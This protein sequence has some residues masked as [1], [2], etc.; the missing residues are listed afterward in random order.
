MPHIF[1]PPERLAEFCRKHHIVKL[2]FFGSVL[3]DDFGP[4]SDV[5]VLVEFDP[6]HIPGLLRFVGMQMELAELLGRAVD[7][8][9][10]NSLSHLLRS[11]I[12][13]EAES[14]YVQ[15]R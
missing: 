13:S 3:R 10:P 4:Q 5:D 9:T 15:A 7:L 11:R 14:Q 8:N 6:A 12:L 2:S 1:I